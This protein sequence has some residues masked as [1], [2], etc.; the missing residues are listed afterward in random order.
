MNGILFLKRDICPEDYNIHLP[1]IFL[2]VSCGFP[3]IAM[4]ETMCYI[5]CQL[6]VSR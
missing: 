3:T 5:K 1:K 4:C 2:L 6:W